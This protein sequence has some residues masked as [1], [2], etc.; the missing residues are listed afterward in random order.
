MFIID[1]QRLS[2]S[3][4]NRYK[5]FGRNVKFRVQFTMDKTLRKG[6]GGGW[7]RGPR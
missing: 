6:C 3:F 5:N 7:D 1:S 4:K 2:G